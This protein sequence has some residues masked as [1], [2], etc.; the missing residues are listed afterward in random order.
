M[1]RVG[2][3]CVDRTEVT[4][5]QY[6]RFVDAVGKDAGGPAGIVQCAANTSLEPVVTVGVPAPPP[7]TPEFPVHGIDWCDAKAYCLWAGKDLCGAVAGGALD[8]DDAADATKST[9]EAICS[10][11]GTQRFGYG[12]S[13]VSG[14]CIDGER[15]IRPADGTCEAGYPGIVDMVGNVGEWVDACRVN[16]PTSFVCALMGV[17][18]SSRITSCT[19]IDVIP[20]HIPWSNAGVRCCA[21]AKD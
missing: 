4:A 11:D 3:T 16:T 2:S 8:P 9:W 15:D 10:K 12:D 17:A 18:G 13:Y 5:A 6:K 7:E 1:I 21:P 14:R 19:E 20:G